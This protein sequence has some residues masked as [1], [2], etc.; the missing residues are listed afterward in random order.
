VF[1]KSQKRGCVFKK[2]QKGDV[3]LK[4]AKKGIK[5]ELKKTGKKGVN[6]RVQQRKLFI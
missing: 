6:C 2:S 3:C 5:N 4:R 1:E